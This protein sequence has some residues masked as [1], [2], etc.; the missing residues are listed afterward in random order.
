MITKDSI[1]AAKE[2]RTSLA[3]EKGLI[4]VL[5]A[6]KDHWMGLYV[7]KKIRFRA[8]YDGKI[9]KEYLSPKKVSKATWGYK[10]GQQA[11]ESIIEALSEVGICAYPAPSCEG[12]DAYGIII[13][14]VP[15]IEEEI[16]EIDEE[17]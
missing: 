17:E 16:E 13:S 7:D 6:K 11:R 12:S 4:K 5:D 15:L 2:K 10:S 14:T 3:G 8:N 9:I 1:I